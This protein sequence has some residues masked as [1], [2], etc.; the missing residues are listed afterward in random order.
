MNVKINVE[1]GKLALMRHGTTGFVNLRIKDLLAQGLAFGFLGLEIL[2]GVT[3][4]GV[5]V[6][7][8]KRILCVRG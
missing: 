3:F 8:R 5:G 2:G 4:G 1:T 6:C 7:L